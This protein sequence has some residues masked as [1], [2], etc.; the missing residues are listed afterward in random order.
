MMGALESIVESVDSMDRVAD[1][2]AERYAAAISPPR[3]PG[4]GGP[5][6]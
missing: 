1:R 2:L 6:T 3:S 4:L 5:A